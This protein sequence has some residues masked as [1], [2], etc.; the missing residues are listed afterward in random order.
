MHLAG[1]LAGLC[2]GP[3]GDT[4]CRPGGLGG[5]DAVAA[6]PTRDVGGVVD[7]EEGAALQMQVAE[8]TDAMVLGAAGSATEPVRGLM[9]M[10]RC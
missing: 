10:L 8:N 7:P 3:N 5:C 6:T 2:A 9:V 4:S 1:A